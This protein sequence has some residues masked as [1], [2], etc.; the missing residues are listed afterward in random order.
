M[1]Y[2][3]EL[4]VEYHG[5]MLFFSIRVCVL[6]SFSIE[7]VEGETVFG[8]GWIGFRRR[9]HTRIEPEMH[10]AVELHELLRIGGWYEVFE[11][12]GG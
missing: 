12:Q 9:L 3:I 1:G 4:S 11:E 5:D 2:F 10:D 8:P 7:R 6:N